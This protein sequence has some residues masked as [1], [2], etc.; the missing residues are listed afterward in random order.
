MSKPIRVEH[1]SLDTARQAIQQISREID[2][3]LDTLRAGLAKLD[4][5]GADRAE[6]ES[7][8]REWDAAVQDINRVLN[9]IGTG[10]GMA[11]QNF[12]DT[13]ETNARIWS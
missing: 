13:E 3:E 7:Y 6:Y 2:E 9:D 5:Q 11:H 10:V 1:L 8:Q 4:W 12:V